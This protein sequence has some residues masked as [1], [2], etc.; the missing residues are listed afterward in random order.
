MSTKY[1]SYKLIV[2]QPTND[3][4][5]SNILIERIKKILDDGLLQVTN[6]S[7]VIDQIMTNCPNL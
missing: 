6:T 2:I 4:K 1:F 7:S 5:S 3:C